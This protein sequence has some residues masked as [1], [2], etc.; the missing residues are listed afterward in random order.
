M[1]AA[2]DHGAG[3]KVLL[4][5]GWGGSWRETWHEPGI[6]ALLSDVGLAPTGIDLLGHGDADKPHDP[7]AYADLSGWLLDAIRDEGPLDAVGFSLGAMTLLGA[8]VREPSRFGRLVLA[9]IGDSVFSPRDDNSHDRIVAA[10]ERTVSDHDDSD[11]AGSDTLALVFRQHATRP[12][13]DLAALTAIMKRPE[14]PTLTPADLAVVTCP[15]LVAIGDK[16]FAAPAD[17]LA[18]AFSDGRLTVLRNTDHFATP[19]SFPF[20]DAVLGFLAP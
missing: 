8:A 18:A 4:V 9:G 14:P 3:R 6:D 20:I 11:D 2:D 17:R 7:A 15:V 13:N 16:D 19:S 5:H 12:G 10:L 1:S